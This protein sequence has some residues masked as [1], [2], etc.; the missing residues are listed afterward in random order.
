MTK[1]AEEM[2]ATQLLAN[3]HRTVEDLFE[4]YE[5]ASGL[6]KKKDLVRQICTELKIHTVIEEEIFYPACRGDVEDEDL[7][8][9][10]VEH[11]SAKVLINE[12]ENASPD[13]AFYD[14]KVTVLQ[15]Q[16][17]H[18]VKEEE[19]QQGNI[20]SQARKAGLD[21]DDLGSKLLARKQELKQQAEQGDLGPAKTT[22]M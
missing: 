21:L 11:D 3:D 4:K 20:F 12:L 6:E 18:H 16:I 13:E 22:T 9:A 8:E 15:E 10:L 14:S 1:N 17:E 7:D 19:R 2:N 5:K